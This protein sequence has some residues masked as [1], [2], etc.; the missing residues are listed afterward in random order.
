MSKHR[1]TLS[2]LSLATV[3]AA[4]VTALTVAAA[5]SAA[6]PKVTACAAV[7]AGI[8]KKLTLWEGDHDGWIISANDHGKVWGRQLVSGGYFAKEELYNRNMPK[9]FE[10]PAE[11]RQRTN[12]KIVL[13]HPSVNI[14]ISYDYGLNWGTHLKLSA[15]RKETFRRSALKNPD[16]QMRMTEGVKFAL[17]QK[18]TD[19]TARHGA[20]AGNTVFADGHIEFLETIPYK[21]AANYSRKFWFN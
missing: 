20:G 21:G 5:K 16:R 11:T 8:E 10:C 18:P 9:N 17:T 15:A 1:F 6:D 4:V 2:E 14:V 3:C 19:V 13:P 12:G 7:M